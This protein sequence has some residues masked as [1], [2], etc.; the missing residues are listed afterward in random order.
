MADLPGHPMMVAG[1]TV[2][3][4]LGAFDVLNLETDVA[5]ADLTGT[6]VESSRPVAVFAGA[7]AANVPFVD[8]TIVGWADHLEEQL[9]PDRTHGT[10]FVVAPMPSRTAAV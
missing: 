9:P 6:V 2:H 7:E 1:S 5:G 4:T 3:V 8:G 10:R